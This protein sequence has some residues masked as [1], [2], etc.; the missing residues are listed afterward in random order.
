MTRAGRRGGSSPPW[1][2]VV[3]LVVCSPPAFA[4]ASSPRSASRPLIVPDVPFLPQT[5]E[6]CG[7][8]ALAMVLRYWGATDVDPEDFAAALN[9]DGSGIAVSSLLRLA[10][11]RGFASLS[12]AGSPAEAVAHLQE[13]RPLIA[14]AASGKSRRHYVVL[15]A[16]ANRRVLLHDPALG[17]FRVVPESDW[18]PRWS[19]TD[20][21]TILVLPRD[22]PELRGPESPVERP[23][24]CARLVTPALDL[25]GRGELGAARER[26]AA[27]ASHCPD[28]SSPHR[29]MAGLEFRR[30]DWSGAAAFAEEAV[31]RDPDDRLAWSLLATSL[32]LDGRREDALRAWN[33]VGEP[34]VDLVRIDGLVRTPFRPLYAHLGF[35]SRSM[36]TA[37]SL[38]RAERRL[39]A[40]PT[41]V[42]A[43]VGYRPLPGG[44]ARLEAAIVERPT[45]EPA[46][47]WLLESAVR[48]ISLQETRLE[49]ANLTPAGDDLRILGRWHPNRPRVAV[50]ASVLRAFG[51]AGVVT[52][53]GSWDE[54]TYRLPSSASGGPVPEPFR[55]RWQ[56]ASL[57]LDNWWTADLRAAFAVGLD[58]WMDN[59]RHL[60]VSV[61][62][63]RRLAGDRLSL[64]ARVAGWTPSASREAFWAATLRVSARSRA[65]AAGALVRLD[66]SYD[67]VTDGAPLS[68][69]P[70]AGTGF[71]RAPLLRAHPLLGDGVIEGPAFGRRLLRA[72]LEAQAPLA[73]LGPVRL[74]A[75]AF[76]DSARIAPL[77]ASAPRTFVDVGAGLRVQLPWHGSAL[78][79]DV[80]T[81]WDRLSPQLSA[82]W[83]RRWPD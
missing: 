58:E 68:L 12:L 34:K 66:L 25:A 80:A 27:A 14:L 20:N 33:R 9:A 29:E 62:L 73:S 13:G 43:R 61:D 45:M 56:H 69:W 40:L 4:T 48:A 55:E 7:G 5:E 60:S 6:L 10:E 19:E 53:E 47:F 78:R 70:G 76:V 17:P 72:G 71:G 42:G 11:A 75:A 3:A 15:L 83:Q 79:V 41:L 52:V 82:G 30:E 8:A 23:D 28:S 46:P 54:Q 63:D 32:F 74:R 31:A 67:V 59:G 49:L 21:A 36:L 18:L 44:R 37:A 50:E 51:L 38:Q 24:S 64:G 26:L 39:D 81:P 77:A 1:C 22:G 65:R 2:V 35:S 16:W 57:S